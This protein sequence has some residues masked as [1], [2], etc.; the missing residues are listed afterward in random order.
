MGYKSADKIFRGH[1]NAI[2]SICWAPHGT[3]IVTASLDSFVYLWDI[4]TQEC[5]SVLAGHRKGVYS[6]DW[7]SDGNFV[8]TASTD[9]TARLWDVGSG[10]EL[11]CL[12]PSSRS[13]VWSTSFNLD[14]TA[15]LTTYSDGIAQTWDVEEGVVIDTLEGHSSWV[16]NCACS[17]RDTNLYATASKDGSTLLWE[18]SS[19]VA[20]FVANKDSIQCLNWSPD[21]R[22]LVT[23]SKD[24]RVRL[25]DIANPKTCRLVL[26]PFPFEVLSCAWSHDNKYIA[27]S[28]A[29]EIIRVYDANSGMPMASWQG[30]QGSITCTSWAPEGLRLAS[31]SSDKSGKMWSMEFLEE[32]DYVPMSLE[33]TA[34]KPTSQFDQT[35]TE[36][37]WKI[38]TPYDLMFRSEMANGE[39]NGDPEDGAG[40]ESSQ[41]D[42]EEQDNDTEKTRRSSVSTDFG[43]LDVL[44]EFRLSLGT[45]ER[46]G[47]GMQKTAGK[48]SECFDGSDCTWLCNELSSL[49]HDRAVTY[50][51]ISED[52]ATISA[53]CKNNALV[54]W[55]REGGK[56]DSVN[57]SSAKMGQNTSCS[58]FEITPDGQRG[59]GGFSNGDME[60]WDLISRE[61]EFVLTGHSNNVSTIAWHPSNKD[62]LA[63]GSHDFTCV[64]WKL[65]GNISSTTLKGHLSYIRDV[66]WSSDGAKLLTASSDNTIAIW[67]GYTGSF[68]G[69]LVNRDT[70]F[71]ASWSPSGEE[72][73]SGSRNGDVKVWSALSFNEKHTLQGHK[74]EVRSSTWGMTP[75]STS[76][77]STMLITGS[78]D[79]VVIFWDP[80]RGTKLNQINLHSG[81]VKG[82]HLSKDGK[83]IISGS[84]DSNVKIL[85][86]TRINHENGLHSAM[87]ECVQGQ[88][89]QD[90]RLKHVLSSVKHTVRN[91][92]MLK[93]MKDKSHHN[94]GTHKVQDELRAMLQVLHSMV[95]TVSDNIGQLESAVVG[96]NGMEALS[97]DLKL[98]LDAL[99]DGH[100]S[101]EYAIR[102][103]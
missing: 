52:C 61:R 67:S 7:S 59:A 85:E 27:A 70:I 41:K 94:G 30:H 63:S 17:P 40:S 2:T 57:Y 73:A 102:R 68:I 4:G 21:G 75:T 97:R 84:L 28:C 86:L 50:C 79:G 19:L 35:D 64:I 60:I 81:A 65:G 89:R 99:Q 6:V 5:L 23:A 37:C 1:K 88:R 56:K 93:A 62:L 22:S 58:C 33:H 10:L 92:D 47:E 90:L 98:A 31:G 34:E 72:I 49:S 3:Q 25:W 36:T 96:I 29:D 91:H 12:M 48:T 8:S 24:C 103:K 18:K 44:E 51:S 71:T 15:L 9:C 20:S 55:K 43:T 77:S 46:F 76:S 100:S 32:E 38:G 95:G 82:I 13:I 45:S 42:I 16:T 11:S 101:L 39:S 74:S 26:P 87:L 66:K 80:S 53:T 14:S 83:T 69:K 54:V 78:W